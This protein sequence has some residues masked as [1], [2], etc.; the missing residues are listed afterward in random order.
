[1]TI[2][3]HHHFWRLSRGDYGW[4]TPDM[5]ALYRNFQP[6]D[7]DQDLANSRIAGTVLVQAAPTEAET[8]YL[9]KLADSWPKALCVVGWTDLASPDAPKALER[10]TRHRLLRGI[11]PMIQD[12]PDPD[13]IFRPPCLSP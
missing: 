8:E 11:R 5:H 3:A 9:L 1:M 6:E 10:L 12:E 7:L 4:L 13:W 2:D